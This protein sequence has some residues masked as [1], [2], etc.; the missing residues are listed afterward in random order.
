MPD[1]RV[2]LAILRRHFRAALMIILKKTD[3]TV[4]QWSP[5]QQTAV[6][7]HQTKLEYSKEIYHTTLQ[8]F[9]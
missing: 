4:S 1:F 6:V 3:S 8:P 9:Y 7:S 5:Q 2:I